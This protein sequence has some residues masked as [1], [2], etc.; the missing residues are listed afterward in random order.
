MTCEDIRSAISSFNKY[1]DDPCSVYKSLINIHI[2]YSGEVQRMQDQSTRFASGADLEE[3]WELAH[4]FLV[5][6]MK[7][8]STEAMRTGAEFERRI[9]PKNRYIRSVGRWRVGTVQRDET[10]L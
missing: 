6:R 5:K 8:V 7:D 4:G 9:V 10:G 3:R 2:Q 1:N